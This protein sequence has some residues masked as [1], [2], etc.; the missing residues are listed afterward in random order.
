MITKEQ[1]YNKYNK[2]SKLNKNRLAGP[3]DAKM[4]LR[5]LSFPIAYFLAKKGVSANIV[6][7][8]FM[9]T[10]LLANAVLPIPTIW[11]LLISL[12]LHEL[13]QLIDCIDGQLARYHGSSFKEGEALD[14]L[15]TILITGT[16]ILAFSLRLY[17]E[18]NNWIY[19]FL[20]GLGAFFKAFEHQLIVDKKTLLDLGL[21][22]RVISQS[23]ILRYIFYGFESVLTEVRLSVAVILLLTLIDEPLHSSFYE[24]FFLLIIFAGLAENL[25]LRFYITYTS[26]TKAKKVAWKGW[27]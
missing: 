27:A 11:A 18:T 21:L 9:F 6:S 2:N 23:K 10:G 1:F 15:I 25:L 14:T 19:L 13:A 22:R 12:V 7:L 16:F 17:F 20:G 5:D 8:I 3:I 26:L 4:F 24:I